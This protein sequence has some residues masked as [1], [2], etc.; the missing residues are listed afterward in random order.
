MKEVDS[1]FLEEG[2]SKSRPAQ[3]SWIDRHRDWAAALIFLSSIVIAGLI[4]LFPYRDISVGRWVSWVVCSL[5]CIGALS[6][7]ILKASGQDEPK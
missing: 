5:I 7:Q 6:W 2:V 1:W 3:Q 4:S